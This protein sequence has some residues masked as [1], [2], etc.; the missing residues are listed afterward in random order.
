MGQLGL[1]CLKSSL[2]NWF[3][4]TVP[5][6]KCASEEEVVCCCA[7]I[8][9]L[10][11][12]VSDP[13]VHRA[14]GP[15]KISGVAHIYCSSGSFMIKSMGEEGQGRIS[16]GPTSLYTLRIDTLPLGGTACWARWA[17]GVSWDGISSVFTIMHA[18][19]PMTGSNLDSIVCTRRNSVLSLYHSSPA[20]QSHRNQVPVTR[21]TRTREVDIRV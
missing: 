11:Y 12:F 14:L 8:H 17:C 5:G 20:R 21:K 9:I 13:L 4:P 1:V 3:K 6:Q 16:L 19:D 10:F 2:N 15:K 7:V 18:P